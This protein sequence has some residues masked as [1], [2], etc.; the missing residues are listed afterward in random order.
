MLKRERFT[1]IDNHSSEITPMFRAAFEGHM[2][3]S[4]FIE[5]SLLTKT[6]ATVI[7]HM[8]QFVFIRE[9]FNIV[10]GISSGP[11]LLH[12][13]LENCSPKFRTMYFCTARTNHI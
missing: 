1:H 4:T 5:T 10:Q 12:S 2:L 3:S 7:N 6:G 9:M 11:N 8:Q 13:N